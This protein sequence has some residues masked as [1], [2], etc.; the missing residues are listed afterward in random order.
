VQDREAR[1]IGLQ[2]EDRAPVVRATASCGPVEVAGAVEDQRGVGICRVG[3]GAGKVAQDREG[4]AISLQRED[5]A[6]AKEATHSRTTVGGGPVEVAGAIED[7]RSIRICPVGYTAAEKAVQDCHALHG[8]DGAAVR[9]TTRVR[10]PVEV[11]GAVKDQRGARLAPVGGAT[12]KGAQGRVARAIGLQRE[13][14][15]AAVDAA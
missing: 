11:A 6:A 15:A 2:R 9:R 12:G 13:D 7:Q 4:R 5:R 8:E 14:G 10:G 1:A 3:E